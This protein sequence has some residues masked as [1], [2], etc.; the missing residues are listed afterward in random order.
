MIVLKNKLLFLLGICM[1]VLACNKGNEA[2]TAENEIKSLYVAG[3]RCIDNYRL[4]SAILYFSQA[5]KRIG[6]H[7]FPWPRRTCNQSRFGESA[8]R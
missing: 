8:E 5:E 1:F 3:R 7:K 4:D 6:V 2:E